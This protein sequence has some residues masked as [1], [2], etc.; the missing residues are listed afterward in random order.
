MFDCVGFGPLPCHN[1]PNRA[2]MDHLLSAKVT[3][4]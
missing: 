2:L 1:F 3:L 4:M